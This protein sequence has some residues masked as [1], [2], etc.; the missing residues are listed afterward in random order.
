MTQHPDSIRIE[1]PETATLPTVRAMTLELL[2]AFETGAPRVVLDVRSVRR[3]D[4]AAMQSLASA[5]RSARELEIEIVFEGP[6][7]VFSTA[8]RRLGLAHADALPLAPTQ[9]A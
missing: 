7:E 9:G 4:T 2:Q 8:A 1:L 6:S 5:C 3:V